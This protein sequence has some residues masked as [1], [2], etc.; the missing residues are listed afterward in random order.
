MLGMFVLREKL[1]GESS[2]LA[3][4]TTGQTHFVYGEDKKF[5]PTAMALTGGI[6]ALVGFGLLS[7]NTDIISPTARTVFVGK[8]IPITSPPPPPPPIED[9][10]P[11]PTPPVVQTA[12]TATK[13]PI[14]IPT[15]NPPI[16][17]VYDGGPLP[18]LDATAGTDI[19][20]ALPPPK[21]IDPPTILP[22]PKLVGV[23]PH[24][25]YAAK[26][27]PDYPS[28]MIRSS[29]EGVVEVKVLVGTDGKV[30]DVQILKSADPAFS[31]A[32]R[33]TALRDWRFMPATRDGV[34]YE[35]WYTTKVIFR[36]DR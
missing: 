7:M 24:P 29:T 26:F 6:V 10:K 16:A 28:A 15:S 33:R 35:Q 13:P 11:S 9:V 36:L 14:D 18:P 31:E 3:R 21:P 2:G 34:P 20:N 30:K 22:P 8:H 19:V 27:Q 25:R 5:S 32:T 17:T 23:K 4:V 1:R 12:I